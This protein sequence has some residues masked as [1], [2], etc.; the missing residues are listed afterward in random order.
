[1][2]HLFCNVCENM[3][4]IKI[5]ANEEEENTKLV[6]KCNNCDI[7]I[8]KSNNNEAV[9][10]QNFN[11]DNIKRQNV[12][13]QYT[14]HDNTLPRALGVKCPNEN[15]PSKKPVIKYIKYDNDNMLYVYICLDCQKAGNDNYIW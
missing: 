2:D 6:Y 7:S 14:I 5:E 15:C 10:Y 4:E 9:Y 12:V 11:H 13:N 3:Y 1:M 8:D